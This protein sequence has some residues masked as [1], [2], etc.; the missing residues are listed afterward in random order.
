[1]DEILGESPFALSSAT[2][3]LLESGEWEGEEATSRQE[4]AARLDEWESELGEQPWSGE[5]ERSS[6]TGRHAA[7]GQ[8]AR[9]G[10]RPP[11]PVMAGMPAP[12]AYRPTA[13]SQ[14]VGYASSASQ[15]PVGSPTSRLVSDAATCP[16]ITYRNEPWTQGKPGRHQTT[17]GTVTHQK[18]AE[19]A[20][21]RALELGD[22]DVD[23]YRLRPAHRGILADLVSAIATGLSNGRIVAPITISVQ[24]RTSSSGSMSHNLAL[25][26]HRAV[27]TA[28]LI[29][30]LAK[31][32]RID[33][34]VHVKWTPLGESVSQTIAGDNAEGAEQREVRVQVIAP[35][36]A[37]FV[38]PGQQ[39]APAAPG[40]LP[41][42]TPGG[43][44]PSRPGLRRRGY[45]PPRAGRRTASLCVEVE[46]VTRSPGFAWLRTGGL[47]T[48][49]VR[50]RV[51]DHR[52]RSAASYVLQGVVIGTAPQP[53]PLLGGALGGLASIARRILGLASRTPVPARGCRPTTAVAVGAD[54]VRLLSGVAVLVIPPAGAGKAAIQLRPRSRRIR[55]A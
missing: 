23:D 24:G 20:A 33:G 21:V 27:N 28:N 42:P 17:D 52:T 5:Q 53:G 39:P 44:M 48:V 3:E 25:S 49:T 12:G 18:V 41:Y 19:N 1:M 36:P 55:L 4:A 38:P 34:Q 29:H 32:A 22:F 14:T 30:C 26:R 35:R 46:S 47:R 15:A 50:I 2:G 31:Q 9:V 6:Q 51:H 45:L 40:R 43:G 7:R 11:A 37:G 10:H 13:P 16:D 54:P 8:A